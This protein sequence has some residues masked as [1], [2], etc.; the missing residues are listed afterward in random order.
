MVTVV[1][2]PLEPVPVNVPGLVI[3]GTPRLFELPPTPGPKN[4][5]HG[6]GVAKAAAM[7]QPVEL[8][9]RANSV[10]GPKEELAAVKVVVSTFSWK[11]GKSN[12]TSTLRN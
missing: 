10:I 4:A 11:L 6:P 7:K 2:T 8:P 3:L 1:V 12:I 9:L 5:Q